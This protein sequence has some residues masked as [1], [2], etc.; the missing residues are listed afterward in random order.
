[1]GRVREPA[2][3]VL[4]GQ[5]RGF[6]QGLIVVGAALAQRGQINIVA[7]VQDFQRGHALAVGRRAAGREIA[8]GHAQRF[9]P[10]RVVVGQI[11]HGQQAAVQHHAVRDGAGDAAV[12]KFIRAVLGQPGQALGQIGLAQEFAF[13]IGAAVFLAEDLQK[14]RELVQAAPRALAAGVHG[15]PVGQGMPHREAVFRIAARRV[16]Q[17]RPGEGRAHAFPAQP[18][19]LVPAGNRAGHGID[20]QIAARGHGLEAPGLVKFR[21]G[22]GGGAP[23]GVQGLE[24]AA[25]GVV[26][27][28][29]AVAAQAAHVRIDHGQHG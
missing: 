3:P 1:M 21:A 27:Q 9:R 28:P 29:E 19:S 20:R 15:Q 14:G 16:Q 24:F 6:R 23:A 12:I 8:V 11:A 25:R 17:L 22:R 7:D 26:N 4:K 2:V 10:V 18:E 13:G 5:A